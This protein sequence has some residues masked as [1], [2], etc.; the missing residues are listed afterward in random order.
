MV[1]R[2]ASWRLS[3]TRGFIRSFSSSRVSLDINPFARHL[4]NIPK[5]PPAPSQNHHDLPS[6]FSYAKQ[7]ALQEMTTT[8]VGTRYEYTVLSTLR[9]FA[10][11]LERI[12]GRDDAG[13]DL[14]GTWH[15]PGR[16]LAPFRVIVQC[17]ALKTKLGPNLV[18][19][20]EGAF[21][22]SPVGWRTSDKVAILVSPREATKGVRDTLRRS[23]Y[24][25]FWMMMEDDGVLRQVLWNSKVEE[26]GLASLGVEARYTQLADTASDDRP[27]PDVVLT[28]DSDDIPDM[29]CV[30]ERISQKEAE[31]LSTWGCQDLPEAQK[32]ELLTMLEDSYPEMAREILHG[33][34][35]EDFDAKK[36]QILLLL[37][38]KF[39]Q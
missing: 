33:G 22:H 24:P 17:K 11:D 23:P 25:L 16:E 14:V 6:F 29:D 12:G 30:E 28:W 10:F 27:R 9:R 13:I 4:L 19:E 7:T 36:A 34:V 31:W 15:V 32:Y 20:L 39:N 37:K 18:R 1:P 8:Y 3:A 35:V 38:D 2:T 21:R 5:A 26:L